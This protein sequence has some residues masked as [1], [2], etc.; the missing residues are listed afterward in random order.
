MAISFH[1]LARQFSPPC[2]TDSELLQQ[3]AHSRDSDAFAEL[4]RRHG[5]VVYRICKRL[6]GEAA[7]DDAFQATFLLL[8]TRTAAAQASHSIGGWL[9][10][11]AGRVARQLRRAARRRHSHEFAAASRAHDESENE[12]SPEL[13]DQFRILDEELARLP[14]RLRDPLVMCLL[15]G[16]T[17]EA[18]A[19]E[20]GHTTRTVRRRLEEAKQVLRLRLQRRGVTATVAAGLVIGL[21]SVSMA[22]PSELVTRTAAVVFD[23]MNGGS[24]ISSPPVLL[25]KGMTTHMLA[26][27]AMA[28]IVAVAVGMTGL[29]MV[30]AEDA[31]PTSD[32]TTAKPSPQTVPTQAAPLGGPVS[33][34]QPPMKTEPKQLESKPSEDNERQIDELEQKLKP[35]EPRFVIEMIFLQAKA[36]FCEGCGLRDVRNPLLSASLNQREMKLLGALIAAKAA[37]GEIDILS[38]PQL[39][40]KDGQTGS[41]QAGQTFELTTYRTITING[42]EVNDAKPT[43]VG[44][45][46]IPSIRFQFTPKIINATGT[47]LKLE[48]QTAQLSEPIKTEKTSEVPSINIETIQTALWVPTQECTLYGIMNQPKSSKTDRTELLWVLT[49]HLVHG[50][51]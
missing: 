31:I 10:G 29:G 44:T 4:V 35:G 6:V 45:S 13:L 43:K 7:A 34:T 20:S 16:H 11:V 18:V 28:V 1:F 9:V 15:Q 33:R 41:T 32:Q 27:K 17:Q 5:P 25:A 2:S 51:P 37:S 50:K 49:T 22:V 38:P 24:A 23:F 8:A 30:L 36:G 3:F 39:V 14:D 12:A 19:S 47:D 40:L 48:I 26:R 46:T 21:E 42:Q